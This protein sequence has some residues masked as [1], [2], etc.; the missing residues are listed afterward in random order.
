MSLRWLL[1]YWFFIPSVVML[2][3]VILG[4]IMPEGVSP[5]T[6]VMIV[7]MLSVII[8]SSSMLL[9]CWESFFWELKCC[10]YAESHYS[11]LLCWV[12]LSRVSLSSVS[13]C[14][15]SLYWKLLCR[16]SKCQRRLIFFDQNFHF[17]NQ[18]VSDAVKTKAIVFWSKFPNFFPKFLSPFFWR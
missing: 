10:C 9:L 4:V 7:V 14:W 2:S 3:F 1:L 11:E 6:I 8:L 5:N 16:L 13:F 15:L 18:K 17:F 12:S